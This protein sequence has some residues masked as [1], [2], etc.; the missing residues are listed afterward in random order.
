MLT[1][2]ALL[3]DAEDSDIG[4]ESEFEEVERETARV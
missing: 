1:V 2:T 3:Q 4:Q